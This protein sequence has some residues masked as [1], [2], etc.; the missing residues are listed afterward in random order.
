[1][2]PSTS[3]ATSLFSLQGRVAL[4]TGASRGLGLSMACAL[5]A[6]GASVWLN[7]R[8][9]EGLVDAVRQADTAGA[10]AGGAAHALPFDVAD[11]HAATAAVDQILATQGR[12]DILINNV[13]QRRREPFDT[14]PA[15]A[16]RK[17]L[18]ANLV[19][20][21]HL[22][23]EAAR[24]MRAQGFGRIINIT[25]IAGPIAR[26]G[27]AAYTTSK[28]ALAALTR[29][30]AA[31]LGPHGINVNAI[32]PGFFATEANATMV[33]DPGTNTWL[34]QRS[35]LGRWGH[36]DEIGGAAVFLASPAAS[37]VTGHVL[38]V[39]GGYLAHF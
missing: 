2:H 36:A 21:W 14:L 15:Q 11:E 32:A 10:T 22:C 6:H 24:P 25:S 18:E 12:L 29:A 20:A 39:D 27:D 8:S 38:A 19:S 1:M 9:V 37:Y 31:E 35:S 13:G 28:G 16:L 30:L 34:Q 23:R 7:G 26:A 3:V 17:V 5:T 33:E 4:V